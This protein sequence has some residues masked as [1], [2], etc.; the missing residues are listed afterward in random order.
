MRHIDEVYPFQVRKV[1]P[2][3]L[4]LVLQLLKEA[5]TAIHQKG[6][7][8]W[9]TWLNP[10]QESIAWI[11]E[12]IANQEFYFVENIS[13]ELMGMYRLSSAD[14]RYWGQQSAKAGYVHSLVVRKQFAGENLGTKILNYIGDCLEEQAILLLRLDCNAANKWLCLYYESQGFAQVGTK[15]MPHSLNNLYEKVLGRLPVV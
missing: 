3:E 10:D 2:V 1:S 9:N 5:A 6:L 15:Q 8:Q 7:D 11:E 14:E 12:G 13:N 4:P